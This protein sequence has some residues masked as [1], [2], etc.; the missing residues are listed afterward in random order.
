MASRPARR[1]TSRSPRRPGCGCRPQVTAGLHLGHRGGPIRRPPPGRRHRPAHNRSAR[2]PESSATPPAADSA[3]PSPGTPRT[4]WPQRLAQPSPAPPRVA[5]GSRAW[6]GPVGSAGAA[7]NVART[8]A[9]WPRPGPLVTWPHTSSRAARHRRHITCCQPEGAVKAS[10]SPS[11]Y[12]PTLAIAGTWS[13]A[14]SAIARPAAAARCSSAASTLAVAVG[15]SSSGD[16]GDS[17]VGICSATLHCFCISIH[18][19]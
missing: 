10:R 8:Q 15:T 2:V 11:S 12:K 9:S 14:D 3:P 4:W 18:I 17:I 7:G 1:I 13:Q 16:P 19:G 6:S 5:A